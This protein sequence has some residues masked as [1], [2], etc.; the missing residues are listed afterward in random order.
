LEWQSQTNGLIHF[1]P[2]M[3]HNFFEAKSSTQANQRLEVPRGLLEAAVEGMQIH[4]YNTCAELVFN[5][6]EIGINKWE[7]RVVRKATIPSAMREQ[8]NSVRIKAHLSGNTYVSW[9]QPHDPF[10]FPSSD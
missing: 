3:P 6:D 10:C 8:Q 7:G 5:L 2:N 9:R 4:A 1:G